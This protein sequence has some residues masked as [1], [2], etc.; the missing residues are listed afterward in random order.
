MILMIYYVSEMCPMGCPNPVIFVTC[1]KSKKVLCLCSTC[2]VYW[3]KSTL[4]SWKMGDI[5]QGD[6]GVK[7]ACPEGVIPSTEN[8]IVLAELEN[9]I[10]GKMIGEDETM[11]LKQLEE[12]FLTT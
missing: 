4:P 7:T 10:A 12:I 8:E 5:G 6:R 9:E 3:D 1:K 11:E 2:R